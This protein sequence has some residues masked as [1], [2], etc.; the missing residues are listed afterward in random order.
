MMYLAQFGDFSSALLETEKES[1]IESEYRPASTKNNRSTEGSYHRLTAKPPAKKEKIVSSS[2]S[3]YLKQ[4]M[5]LLLNP[6][7]ED[8]FTKTH[9]QQVLKLYS[10]EL[11]DKNYH[12]KKTCISRLQN[13]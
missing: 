1:I 12:Y 9:L 11:P 5:F 10:K 4:D 13:Q 8:D 2:S 7:G 3:T 6:R